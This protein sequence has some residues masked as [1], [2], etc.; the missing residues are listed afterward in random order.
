[1]MKNRALSAIGAVVGFALGAFALSFIVA[2]LPLVA[3]SGQ[4]GSGQLWGNPTTGQNIPRATTISSLADISFGSTPGSVPIRGTTQW[5]LWI[6]SSG[7]IPYFSATNTLSSSLT[8]TLNSLMIGGGAGVA[9]TALA[10]SG[11]NHLLLHGSALAPSFGPLNFSQDSLSGTLTTGLIDIAT[12]S[13]WFNNTPNKV[14]TT[15]QIWSSGTLTTLTH[16]A[17]V[18]PDFG[19]GI[20]FLWT[21]TSTPTT[22]ANPTNAK[23]GQSG[24]IYLVNSL[25]S[26][27][28]SLGTSWKT[29]GGAGI[30]PSL[31][32]G[33]VDLLSYACRTPTFCAI[34]KGADFR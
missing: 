13:Q 31:T 7:G 32:N 24:I 27:T 8:L 14:L 25:T 15:D 29:A 20:N 6:G 22:L 3:Q 5:G 19:L 4:I 33:S 34:T 23:V 2:P 30:T 16:G 1:M 12:T 10:S 11:N 21:L 9:P 28:I 26:A 17:S 18:A